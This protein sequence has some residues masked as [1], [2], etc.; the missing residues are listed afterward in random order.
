LNR[1]QIFQHAFRL[2]QGKGFIYVADS[3]GFVF[4]LVATA[5]QR[6]NELQSAVENMKL[7]P[8]GQ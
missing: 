7:V 4:M 3:N 1:L 8:E 2:L 6:S 5:M